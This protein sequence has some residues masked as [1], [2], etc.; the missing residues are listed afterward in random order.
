MNRWISIA[1]IVVGAA[2]LSSPG[3]AKDN[4][5]PNNGNAFGQAG[6]GNPQFQLRPAGASAGRP[7]EEQVESPSD[8]ML[9]LNPNNVCENSVSSTEGRNPHC[10]LNP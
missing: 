7:A 2:I 9:G 10:P 8:E 3:W 6:D 5:K 4:P 1:L